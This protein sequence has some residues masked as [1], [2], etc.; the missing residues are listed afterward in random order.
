LLCLRIGDIVFRLVYPLALVRAA[1]S[2]KAKILD[3]VYNASN[4]ELVRTKTLVKG[5]IVQIDATPFKTHY[6]S[7]YGLPK[8]FFVQAEPQ[9]KV[10]AGSR[11]VQKKK[12]KRQKGRTL[13]KELVDQL[14]KGV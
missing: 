5:A 6:T 1:H 3:V 13:D 4:N 11:S 9:D 7:H 14:V 8:D 10:V 2:A 12:E